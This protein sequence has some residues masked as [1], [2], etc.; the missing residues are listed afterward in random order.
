MQAESTIKPKSYYVENCGGTAE[1]VLYENIKKHTRKDP[2]TEETSTYYTYDEHRINVPF[3]ENLSQE[4][5]DNLTAIG[6]RA[7]YFNVS[8]QKN[9]YSSSDSWVLRMKLI[10]KV[11]P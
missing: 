4:V 9:R 11:S 1:V 5:K 3:R 8:T 6:I 7:H 10:Y 2:E